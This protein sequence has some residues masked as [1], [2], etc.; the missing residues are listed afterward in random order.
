MCR[1]KKIHPDLHLVCF[2][3]VFQTHEC[4]LLGPL[5]LMDTLVH[6]HIHP[7]YYFRT[8]LPIPQMRALD[9]WEEAREPGANRQLFHWH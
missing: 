3:H 7:P 9:L 2:H 1:K 5:Q 6:N 4:E 8:Y